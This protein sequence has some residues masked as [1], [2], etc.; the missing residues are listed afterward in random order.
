M[1]TTDER[2]GCNVKDQSHSLPEALFSLDAATPIALHAETTSKGIQKGAGLESDN[3]S[4]SHTCGVVGGHALSL[5][6]NPVDALARGR[7]VPAPQQPATRART[8][9]HGVHRCGDGAVF[10][11]LS[12]DVTGWSWA[13]R[14]PIGGDW[15]SDR[16][17]YRPAVDTS[18]LLPCRGPVSSFEGLLEHS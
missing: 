12:V 7:A 11:L 15:Q 14:G 6:G 5:D 3:A 17:V 16:E 13:V 9:Q 1:D 8:L 2:P 10:D 18:M 4:T